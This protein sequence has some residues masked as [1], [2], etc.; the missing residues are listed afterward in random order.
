[1]PRFLQPE[2]TY[3]RLVW[4]KVRPLF[5]VLARRWRL[6]CFDCQTYYRSRSVIRLIA[7]SRIPYN[8]Y[9]GQAVR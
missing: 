1:M 6:V 5:A 7:I 2:S 9:C 4:S 8:A 3:I